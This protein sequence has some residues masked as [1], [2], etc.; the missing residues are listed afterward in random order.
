MENVLY[1]GPMPLL[2]R[3]L[4]LSSQQTAI[5]LNMGVISKQK[6]IVFEKKSELEKNLTM[7]RKSRQIKRLTAVPSGIKN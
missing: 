2:F 7:T 1:D 6:I 4:F 3:G 5:K